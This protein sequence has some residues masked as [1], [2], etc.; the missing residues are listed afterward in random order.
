MTTTRRKFIK[1]SGTAL[2]SAA[3]LSQIPMNLLTSCSKDSG[4]S[5]GFQ[6]WTI[7]K[8]LIEDFANTLKEMSELGYSEVEMCSPLGYSESGFGPLH[9]IEGGEMRK[10]IEDS[11]LTCTSSHFTPG[12]LREHLENRIEWAHDLGMKQMILSSFW[13]QQDAS[14]DDFRRAASELN[15]IGEKTKAAGIQMGFHNHH[16]EFEKRGDDLVY[17]VLL[18]EFDPDLVKMQFQVAVVNIGYKAADYFRKHPGCFI[19][20]HLVDWSPEKEETVPVGQGIVDWPDFFEAAKKGG[21]KNFYVEIAPE[22]FK[23]SAE[24][25]SAL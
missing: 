17:D 22:M 15:G 21:V 8:K 16:M 4:L 19:S 14:L 23:E 7:R 12:E 9:E 6:V 1:K 11:G 5:L 13:L 20:S 18:D 2:A 3:L 24:F 10:I 25:L